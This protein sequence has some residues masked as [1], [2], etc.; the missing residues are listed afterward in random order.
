MGMTEPMRAICQKQMLPTYWT[1]LRRCSNGYTQNQNAYALL[2]SGVMLGVLSP[3]NS[4]PPNNT[5]KR[6]CQKR[7]AAEG[8]C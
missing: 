8:E 6:M 4:M 2:K 3:S 1:F 7:R 5:F